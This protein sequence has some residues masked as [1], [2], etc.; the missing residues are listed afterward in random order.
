[1][2]D[3]L[4]NLFKNKKQKKTKIMIF[5]YLN[6]LFLKLFNNYKN[7]D[8]L[9]FDLK[10][11]AVLYGYNINRITGA[12]ILPLLKNIEL[13]NKQSEL[14][15]LI[16]VDI[17]LSEIYNND[18]YSLDKIIDFYKKSNADIL[19]FNLNYITGDLVSKLTKIK[20]PVIIYAENTSEE[21]DKIYNKLIET[22]GMG[23]LLIILE[24]F[25]NQFINKLK[26]SVSIPVVVNDLSAKCDGYYA[27]FISVFGMINDD[28]KKF[29]NISDLINDG[30]NDYL[31]INKI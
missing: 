21:S 9:R 28:K 8:I 2:Y 13:S 6:N 17:P 15:K 12:D 30:I 1:M 22:E 3:N 7:I 18:S 19:I 25:N 10:E 11:F 29:L 27:Q 26:N 20:I 31:T 23:A 14:S 16:A 5:S 24:N 4:Y